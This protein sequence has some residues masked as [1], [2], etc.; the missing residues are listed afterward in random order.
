MSVAFERLVQHLEEYELRFETD[1]ENET[2]VAS[3]SG[4]VASYRV[5]G[6]IEADQDLFQVFGLIPIRVPKGCRPAVAE[7]ITRAN[8]GLKVGNFEMDFDDGELRY[9]I[10]HLLAG[11]SLDGETVRRLIGTTMAMMDRYLPAILSV[12]YGNELP[13]DAVR[14]AESDQEER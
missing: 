9:Q 3:F 1:T 6:R 10:A 14:F 13:A 5:I 2:I 7:A 8:F 11:D 12:I 4:Q